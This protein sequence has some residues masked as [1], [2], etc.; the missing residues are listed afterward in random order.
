[1]DVVKEKKRGFTI[2]S[3]VTLIVTSCL[4]AVLLSLILSD[5]SSSFAR[6]ELLIS[7]VSQGDLELTVKGSGNLRSKNISVISAPSNSVVKEIYLR[8]GAQVAP[9]DSIAQLENLML[10]QEVQAADWALSQAKSNYKKV[11]VNNKMAMLEVLDSITRATSQIKVSQMELEATREIFSEGIVSEIDFKKLQAQVMQNQ[12]NLAFLQDKKNILSEAHNELLVIA[13]EEVAQKE[14]EFVAAQNRLEQLTVKANFNGILHSMEIEPGQSLVLGD[15]IALIGSTDKLISI[16]RV[17]QNEVSNVKIGD[18]AKLSNGREQFEGIVERVA[19]VVK[20]NSVEVEIHFIEALPQSVRS[21]QRIDATI[22]TGTLQ[23]VTY[24]TR[25]SSS[26]ENTTL[27]LFK[28]GPNGDIA[29]LTP[30]KMGKVANNKIVI[31]GDVQRGDE[32]IV[33]DM[34][35]LVGQ[36]KTEITIY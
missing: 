5:N 24:I 31:Q 7:S 3:K 12:Q 23:D 27:S 11:A 19:P 21:Q 33:S 29:M 25:A 26:R 28:L 30:F 14:K 9:G 2:S 17:P 18:V 36:K 6:S 20:D 34:S 22:I 8:P 16:V 15:S 1:M 32:I 4:L 10:E 13:N 35:Q